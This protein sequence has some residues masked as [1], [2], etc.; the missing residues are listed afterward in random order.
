VVRVAIDNSLG[1][2]KTILTGSGEA[3]VATGG[4]VT[5]ATWSKGGPTEPLRLVDAQG[6]AIRLAP[7][8]TWIELVPVSGSVVINP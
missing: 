8:N 4:S 1:V 5:A 7:G 2:P 3:T 6:A